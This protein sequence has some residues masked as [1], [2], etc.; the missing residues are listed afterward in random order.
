MKAIRFCAY[1]AAMATIVLMAIG[2]ILNSPTFVLGTLFV[3]IIFML[4]LLVW[5]EGQP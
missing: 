3:F 1:F 2:L 4:A 5:L